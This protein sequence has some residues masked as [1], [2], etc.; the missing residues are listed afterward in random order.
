MSFWRTRPF[1]RPTALKAPQGPQGDGLEPRVMWTRVASPGGRNCLRLHP[2]RGQGLAALTGSEEVWTKLMAGGR[3]APRPRPASPRPA[4]PS[5]ARPGLRNQVNPE[6]VVFPGSLSD[7]PVETQ[8]ER[9]GHA[10]R[11][12]GRNSADRLLGPQ[13]R[14]PAGLR[15]LLPSP[16]LA[17]V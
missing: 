11:L 9:G 7:R 10:L 1:I 2:E 15:A 4:S 16:C 14:G 13:P 5:P 17:L 8:G 6:K 3:K 12:G